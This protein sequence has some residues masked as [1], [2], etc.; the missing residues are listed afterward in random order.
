MKS[1][2]LLR[3]LRCLV[4]HIDETGTIV[5][6]DGAMDGIVGYTPSDLVGMHAFDFVSSGDHEILAE[7]FLAKDE[8]SP[9]IKRPMPM[10][11]TVAGRNGSEELVDI[12]PT[13][14]GGADGNGW[15]A[16]IT[17]RRLQSA[18]HE[19]VDVVM[20]GEPL[21]AVA[22]AL[23]V[24]NE[25]VGDTGQPVVTTYVV[26]G[27]GTA[28]AAVVSLDGAAAVEAALV[29]ERTVSY[30]RS[31]QRTDMIVTAAIDDVPEP[32]RSAALAE[33][34][35]AIHVG[36]AHDGDSVEWWIVWLVDDVR[37][38]TLGL[39]ADI[40]RRAMLRVAS[41]ALERDRVERT[42]RLA[43][44]TDALT[45]LGNRAFFEQ[46]LAEL[47]VTSSVCVLYLDLDRFKTI[48]D[49]YGHDVGD[50]VLG[51]VGA[52]ISSVCRPSDLVARIGG[53]EFAIVLPG[54][55]SKTAS[56]VADRLVAVIGAPLEFESGPETATVT[57]GMA[58]SGG[59]SDLADLVRTADLAMLAAK[60][61]SVDP[62]TA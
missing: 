24:R 62:S 22:R 3:H 23:A 60:R 32:L 11:I 4:V 15:I 52:R 21:V 6:A 7:I 27:A 41:Y 46:S 18:A 43:A 20:D 59:G 61:N 56:A 5:D 53:D 29:D 25:E 37:F 33:G 1:A 31:T 17:P 35:E 2:H 16:T 30:F 58:F 54:T 42:L 12:L 57:V 39:N 51:E 50:A 49:V 8:G 47:S 45:G 10:P 44:T 14:L 36:R 48:N 19:I 40:P 34:Y 26:M 28:S 9:L 38:A 55:D 13:G